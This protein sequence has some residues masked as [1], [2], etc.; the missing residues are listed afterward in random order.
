MSS[1]AP[2]TNRLPTPPDELVAPTPPSISSSSPA[3]P[4]TSPPVSLTND[5]NTSSNQNWGDDQSSQ[6][7]IESSRTGIVANQSLSEIIRE[8][9]RIETSENRMRYRREEEE[10]AQARAARERGERG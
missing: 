4:P 5:L 6:G 3:Q 2:S 10:Q 8:R 9:W 7:G 1:W